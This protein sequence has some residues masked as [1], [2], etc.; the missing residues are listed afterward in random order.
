M[1]Y[2]LGFKSI[3]S[4]LF[5]PL[6]TVFLKN[7]HFNPKS[8]LESRIIKKQKLELEHNKALKLFVL[9]SIILSCIVISYFVAQEIPLA[10]TKHMKSRIT[11]PVINT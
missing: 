7:A 8:Y 11:V 3:C 1:C 6:L 4:K 5:Y 10:P 2:N 9:T